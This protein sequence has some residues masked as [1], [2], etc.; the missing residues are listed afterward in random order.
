MSFAYIIRDKG[1]ILVDAGV[2]KQIDRFADTCARL[3]INPSD[4]QLIVLTH[5]HW[6]HIGSARAIKDL[7]GAEIALH[8]YEKDCLQESL[9]LDVHG[10]TAFGKI[11]AGAIRLAG[12]I[13]PEHHLET[14]TV[15]VVLRDGVLPL[16]I[17]GIPGRIFYTPGHT[18]GSVSVLLDNGDAMVG[19]LAMG[20]SPLGMQAGASIFAEDLNEVYKSWKKILDAGAKTIYP[21][22]GKRFPASRLADLLKVASSLHS[23]SK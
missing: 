20:P 21:S 22:H 12:R 2:P 6:D 10:V 18:N 13:R 11:M 14:A 1:T 15:D 19:D 17:Y 4:I 23:A 8:E 7:T 16:A 5:G 9:D 3:S